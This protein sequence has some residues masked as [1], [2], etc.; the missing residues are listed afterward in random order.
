M[1]V[2]GFILPWLCVLI[3]NFIRRKILRNT[4]FNNS[5]ILGRGIWSSLI[6]CLPLFIYGIYIL[7]KAMYSISYLPA[8][9]LSISSLALFLFSLQFYFFKELVWSDFWK[10]WLRLVAILTLCLNLF[11]TVIYLIP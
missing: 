4:I 5:R 8:Y 9:L 2:K 1:I 10:L 11:F 6:L 3:Y 7:T